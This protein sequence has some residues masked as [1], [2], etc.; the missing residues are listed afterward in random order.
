VERDPHMCGKN[1]NTTVETAMDPEVRSRPYALRGDRSRRGQML[2]LFAV[3]V[4]I[5]GAMCVLAIDVGRLFVCQAELQD[6][7]DAAALAGA[8]QL[9]GTVTPT[10]RAQAVAEATRL[11]AANTVAHTPLTLGSSDVQFGHYD[12]GT[13]AFVSEEVSGIVDSVRITGRRTLASPDGPVDLFFGPLFGWRQM[14]FNDV[15]SV[16]TKPRRYVV[17]VLDRSGSM[18]FDT[19]G[20]QLKST[21]VDPVDPVMVTSPSG[22]Y[23]FPDAALK[24]VSGSWYTTTN[25][26]Y[27]TDNATGAYRTDFLP[28]HIRT[29]VDSGR[30]FNFRS[31]DYPTSVISGW[32]KVPAGVTIHGRYTSPWTYWQADT[33]YAVIPS[34]CGY[35][36]STGPVQPLQDTMDAACTFVDLLQATDDTAGLVT[37]ASKA[38][39]DQVLTNNFPL[40]KTKLQSFAPSG[41]TAE[42]DA[43]EN[44]NAELIDSGR[45]DGFG[46]RIMILLTDGQA[47]VLHG[48]TYDNNQRTYTFLGQTVTSKIHP[49]IASVMET[50][51]RRADQHHVRIYSV[52]FGNDADSALHQAMSNLTGG[53]Y[54]YAPDHTHLTDIFVDIFRRLP[55]IITQ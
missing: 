3:L 15:V 46:Q 18:C 51:A 26:F 22:W 43:M 28:D 24:Y 34:S 4:L 2:V 21:S 7:V 9:L 16:A 47:N 41:G 37:F 8:S 52:S 1:A 25:W 23:W 32:I 17:F 44:A 11:A 31:V 55:P 13:E 19:Q 53:A 36:T 35:A 33:Y 29:R 39:T 45:A 42:P 49:T 48:S 27:A 12:E 54:Y 5:L 50:Q 6:A 30:Y 10:I 38:N 40:L 14:Q 20:V